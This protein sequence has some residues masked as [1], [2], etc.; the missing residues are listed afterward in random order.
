MHSKKKPIVQEENLIKTYSKKQQKIVKKYLNVIKYKGKGFSCSQVSS[1]THAK[2]NNVHRWLCKN[3]RPYPIRTI[4]KC[5]VLNWLPLYPSPE[6]ARLIGLNM[7]DGSIQT[8][9]GHTFFCSKSKDIMDDL[10]DFLFQHFG[11]IGSVTEAGLMK[12]EHL[13]Q[14]GDTAFT[15]LLHNA[16]CP[17]GEKVNQSFKTPAWIMNPQSYGCNDK[18]SREIQLAF[19]QGLNDSETTKFSLRNNS[20]MALEEIKFEIYTHVFPRQLKFIEQLQKLFI[21]FSIKSVIYYDWRKDKQSWRIGL[22]I[23][24]LPNVIRFLFDVGFFFNKDRMNVSLNN[25]HEVCNRR[26][27][28]IEKCIIAMKMIDNGLSYGKVSQILKI[29]ASTIFGWKSVG[30]RPLYFGRKEELQE[31][32]KRFN[33]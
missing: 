27:K 4:E 24:E 14:I 32:F 26:S 11:V 29:P 20:K 23:K 28:N 3:A 9:F 7:G 18:E 31:L 21:N 8:C 2:I 1:L 30:K 13:L 25:C 22:R 33:V 12:S 17:K 5:K 19:L 15:R 10:N 6:L 16:G